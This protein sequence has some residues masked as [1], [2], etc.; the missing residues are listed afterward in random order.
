MNLKRLLGDEE[1]E[2][3]ANRAETVETFWLPSTSNRNTVAVADAGWQP[4]WC[5]DGYHVN[6]V[7][8]NGRCYWPP[9]DVNPSWIQSIPSRRDPP[10]DWHPTS[11][12]NRQKKNKNKQIDLDIFI[13]IEWLSVD[14]LQST[15]MELQASFLFT[16]TT[17]TSPLEGFF[18]SFVFTVV[19]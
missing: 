10:V 11:S 2:L 7:A 12:A 1:E 13:R 4:T 15:V 9:F 14:G 3:W 17:T 18:F 19:V 8:S 5:L 16:L 6:C